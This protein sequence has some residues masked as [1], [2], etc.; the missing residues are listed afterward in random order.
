M[1]ATRHRSAALWLNARVRKIRIAVDTG[2]TFT[3]VVA[4][5]EDTGGI[6]TIKMPSTPADPA[7]G[8]MA[9]IRRILDQVGVTA[10]NINTICNGTTVATT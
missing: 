9:G 8:F 7:E 6:A 4:F 3:D 5:D 2:G 10:A 1:P